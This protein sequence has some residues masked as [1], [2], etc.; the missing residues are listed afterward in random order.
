[1]EVPLDNEIDEF[2]ELIDEAPL[3]GV[4]KD[5]VVGSEVG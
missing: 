4:N 5:L 3:P 1:M 2:G